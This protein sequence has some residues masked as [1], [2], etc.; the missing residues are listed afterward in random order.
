M[1]VTITSQLELELEQE[2]EQDR[3]G[4]HEES[5]DYDEWHRLVE[6]LLKGQL[7][8]VIHRCHEAVYFYPYHQVPRRLRDI[9]VDASLVKS[10][11]LARQ[12]MLDEA[13]YVVDRGSIVAGQ[14]RRKRVL[15]EWLVKLEGSL[16]EEF[17][18]VPELPP[19]NAAL[20]C[21]ESPV[22]RSEPPSLLAFQRQAA[23]NAPL[24]IQNAISDWPALTKWNPA[25]L[26]SR[27]LQ[28]RRLLPVEIG[29]SYVHPD[30]L[31]TLMPARDF[32]LHHLLSTQNAN[33]T[34]YMAQHD[35]MEHVPALREDISIPDYCYID[36]PEYRPPDEVIINSWLGPKGT[37]SPLHTDPFHNLLTQV[38]GYKLVHLY[39]PAET[40]N[41]YPIKIPQQGISME[42]TSSVDLKHPDHAQFPDFASARG[43]QTIIAPG[44]MLYIPA[45]WWHHVESLS[46]SWSVSFWF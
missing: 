32:V 35:L 19:L 11:Q 42:N 26:L 36:I 15:Q 34:A 17:M 40:E 28:G 20:P 1:L 21:I 22:E 5:N 45:G 23:C 2:L 44:E 38:L 27:T 9:L 12:G 24:I 46:V 39:P 41:L 30:W 18:D 16:P 7:D 33:N 37:I 14:G 4:Y 10:V 31:Q 29:S 3:G 25:Y 43:L 8:A 13:V 6:L